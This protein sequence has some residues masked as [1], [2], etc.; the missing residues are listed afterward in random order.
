MIQPLLIFSKWGLLILRVVVGLVLVAYGW[1]K[2]K[3]LKTAHKNFE[4]MGFKPG[5][6]WGT[7]VALFEFVGGILLIIGFFSQLIG[8]LI[9]I[10]FIVATLFNIK[11]GAKLVGGYAIDIL[12][13]ASGFLIATS[14]GH[15][16]LGV[17]SLLGIIIY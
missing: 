17:D 6:L 5:S 3:D 9:V 15:F 13:L 10:E 4:M 14:S 8:A 2:I 7:I 1:P 11:R 16:A 12:L